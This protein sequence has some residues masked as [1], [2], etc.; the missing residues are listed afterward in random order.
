MQINSLNSEGVGMRSSSIIKEQV[1]KLQQCSQ[2][3]VLFGNNC[4]RSG[5]EK[6]RTAS[7]CYIKRK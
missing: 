4:E 1:A 5:N 3:D 6:V 7:G 2:M